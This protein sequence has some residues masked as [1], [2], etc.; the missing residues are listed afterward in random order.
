VPLQASTGKSGAVKVDPEWMSSYAGTVEKAGAEVSEARKV[1]DEA[2][3]RPESFGELGRTLHLADA[4][5]KA[6][7]QLQQQ[8]AR[9]GEVLTAAAS[10][11]RAAAAHYGGHDADAAAQITRSDHR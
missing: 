9:A 11:L 2:P 5:A 1:L 7:G 3:L 6:A 4:Y 8:L 10:G